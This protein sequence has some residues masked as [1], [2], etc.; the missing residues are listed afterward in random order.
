KNFNCVLIY[1]AAEQHSDLRSR[2]SLPLDEPVEFRSPRLTIASGENAIYLRVA[3]KF[4]NR[5]DRIGQLFKRAMERGFQARRAS[6]NSRHQIVVNRAAARRL[7]QKSKHETV[8]RQSGEGARRIA[9]P[10]NLFFIGHDERLA[11]S[12]HHSR[13][14]FDRR[15]NF[16]NQIERRRQT[17]GLVMADDFQAVGPAAFRRDGVFDRANDD[18]ENMRQ[19][20]AV[21]ISVTAYPFFVL[22]GPARLSI[23]RPAS[24]WPAPWPALSPA[25]W[26]AL[27]QAP[28][29]ALCSIFR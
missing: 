23:D 25:P 6:Q 11:F 28:W 7:F 22:S 2:R 29:R 14:D 10:F 5:C 19:F 26:P 20:S 17:A 9:Q 16:A 12:Q 8:N 1:P 27:S 15:S 21:P 18:F 13:G 24:A 4:V 3:F